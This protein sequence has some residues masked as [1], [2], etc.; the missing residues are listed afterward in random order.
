MTAV[1]ERCLGRALS[2]WFCANVAD[3]LRLLGSKANYQVAGQKRGLRAWAKGSWSEFS[4]LGR[5]SERYP[6]RYLN[7]T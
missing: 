4:S 7:D 5:R 1:W 2:L 3:E 6:K